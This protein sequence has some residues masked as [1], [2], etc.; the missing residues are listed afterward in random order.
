M[1]KWELTTRAFLAGVMFGAV[2][3]WLVFMVM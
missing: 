3:T 1:N 2:C